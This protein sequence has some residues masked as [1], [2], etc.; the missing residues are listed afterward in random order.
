MHPMQ[1]QETQLDRCS[2]LELLDECLAGDAVATEELAVR[3]SKLIY[4]IAMQKAPTVGLAMTREDLRDFNQDI[5]LSLFKDDCRRLRAFGRRSSYARWISVIV[6]NALID[7]K[8]SRSQQDAEKTDS[9]HRSL[10]DDPDAATLGDL[11]PDLSSDPREQ[12]VYRG[13]VQAVRQARETV[14]GDEE[15]LII[16]LWC[17]RRHS[18]KEIGVLTG[19]NPN[20][21]AT[22]ISR[23]QVKIL[24]YL[25]NK[26]GET[27]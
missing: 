8:R 16:D 27:V 1:E 17:S 5:L 9:L 3:T 24:T 13:L 11:I 15:R 20:T 18:E 4:M 7:R 22:I 2:D 25:K 26:E 21:V 23:A 19:R 10:S 12:V 14:L 6:A